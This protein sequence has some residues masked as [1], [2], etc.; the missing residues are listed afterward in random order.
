[1][2]SRVASR[3]HRLR[4]GGVPEHFN[5]PWHSAAS[6]GAFTAAGLQID[7]VDFPGGTGAMNKALRQ[8][9]IDVALALT[10]GLVLDLHRGNPSKLIGTYVASPLTW[11]AHVRQSSPLQSMADVDGAT[12]GVSRMG[13]GSHLMACVDAHARGRKAPTLEIVGSLDGAR[14]ALRDGL[15][16]VFLWEKFTT[17]FLVDANEWRRIGEVPTPWPCFMIA[18]SD[19][20]IEESRGPL[21]DMLEVVRTEARDLRASADCASTI[22]LMYAQEPEDIIEWLG[23]VRWCA[24]PVVPHG[25]LEHVM[26]SLVEAGVLQRDERL[27]AGALVSA[28]SIDGDPSADAV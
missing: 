22:G 5:A 13:S 18:A 7:W 16:D 19:A 12:F 11:G 2:A 28:L 27:P 24:K 6:K 25:T 21:L 17:K 1:M 10:E 9:E 20:A 23:G 14:V 26:D 4:V 3:L 8:G 15:A